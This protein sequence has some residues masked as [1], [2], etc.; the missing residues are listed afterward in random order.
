MNVSR[1]HPPPE[2]HSTGLGRR[3]FSL[4]MTKPTDFGLKTPE[5]PQLA[6]A[7]APLS[8]DAFGVTGLVAKRQCGQLCG[9]SFREEAFLDVAGLLQCLV[10]SRGTPQSCGCRFRNKSTQATSVSMLC[11]TTSQ[12]PSFPRSLGWACGGR[13]RVRVSGDGAGRGGAGGRTPRFPRL[14][15]SK[16]QLRE[17]FLKC[18]STLLLDGIQLLDQGFDPSGQC[19]ER[20]STETSQT[21]QDITPPLQNVVLFLG[22]PRAGAKRKHPGSTGEAWTKPTRGL[23]ASSGPWVPSGVSWR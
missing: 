10:V 7:S 2:V 4:A 15:A 8:G 6:S 22:L 18:A 16:R 13:G 23:Q 12:P 5:S 11:R 9:F 3:V 14:P 20:P 19:V 21:Q 1:L 17:A